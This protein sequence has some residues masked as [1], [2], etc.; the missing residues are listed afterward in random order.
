[1]IGLVAVTALWQSHRRV[2][3]PPSAGLLLIYFFLLEDHVLYTFFVGCPNTGETS[4]LY[5]EFV[6]SIPFAAALCTSKREA[7]TH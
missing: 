3:I 5:A 2:Q 1:M 4:L 7:Q 6:K